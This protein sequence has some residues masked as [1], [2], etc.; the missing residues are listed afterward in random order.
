MKY[1]L[2]TEDQIRAIEDALDDAHSSPS[3]KIVWD[4]LYSLKAQEPD[5]WWDNK[6]YVKERFG[7]G[8]KIVGVKHGLPAGSFKREWVGMTDEELNNIPENG[9]TDWMK[10]K[11]F[12][13]AIED[14]LKEKNN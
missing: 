10:K 12:A 13:R 8:A 9:N 4:V 3:L 14:K 7:D 6:E 2:I 5:N 11:S 1:A